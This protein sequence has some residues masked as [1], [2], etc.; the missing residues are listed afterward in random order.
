MNKYL[1]YGLIG[2][3]ALVLVFAFIKYQKETLE[4]Q[5]NDDMDELIKKIDEAKK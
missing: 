1:K 2:A 5:L 3:G 4:P